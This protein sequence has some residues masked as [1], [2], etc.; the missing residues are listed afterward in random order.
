MHTDEATHQAG[1]GL[2]VHSLMRHILVYVMVLGI[3]TLLR[4]LSYRC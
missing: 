1:S 2:I 3:Y 4:L